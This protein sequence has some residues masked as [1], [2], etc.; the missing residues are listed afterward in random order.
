MSTT[1]VR[2]RFHALIDHIEDDRLKHLYDALADADTAPQEITDELTPVQ[3]QRLE[4]SLAQVQRGDVISH[5]DVK[6]Q[7]DEWLSR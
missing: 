4:Y 6:Q 3:R 5:E 7:I 2:A 1:Q